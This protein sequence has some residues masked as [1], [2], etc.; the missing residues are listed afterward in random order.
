MVKACVLQP[1]ASPVLLKKTRDQ[2]L[3]YRPRAAFSNSPPSINAI[4]RTHQKPVAATV[5]PLQ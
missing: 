2:K 1:A 3:E 4:V 5:V